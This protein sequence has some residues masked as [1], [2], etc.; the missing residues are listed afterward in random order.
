MSNEEYH[1]TGAVGKSML[2]NIHKSPAHLKIAGNKN[3]GPPLILGSALHCA[4]LEHSTFNDR[5]IVEPDVDKRTKAGKEEYA[6]FL[7]AMEK[8]GSPI[9]LTQNQLDTVNK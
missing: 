1:A 8:K 2:D 3:P 4:V 5:Y 6:V 7:H 9:I